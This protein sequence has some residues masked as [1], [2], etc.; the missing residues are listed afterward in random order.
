MS[1]FPFVHIA[2]HG[3][4]CHKVVGFDIREALPI[5][6]Y[7]I[8]GFSHME[9]CCF[10]CAFTIIQWQVHLQSKQIKPISIF[11]HVPLPLRGVYASK[12][13]GVRQAKT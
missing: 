12:L 11:V 7:A 4:S 2:K 5:A 1:L 6:K 3:Y 8:V 10:E 9:R 13:L